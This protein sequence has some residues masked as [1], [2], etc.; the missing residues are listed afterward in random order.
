MKEKGIDI[1]TW[2]GTDVNFA[3]LK[4]LGYTFVIMRIGFGGFSNGF[5]CTE[6]NAFEE[7]YPKAKA[8]GL[9]IGGYWYAGASNVNLAEREAEFCIK[10]LKDK[11]CDLPIFYDVEE[12][13]MLEM[14][15]SQLDDIVNAFCYKLLKNKYYAG[16]YGGFALTGKL[17]ATTRNKYPVW[18]AQWN[19]EC[20][21]SGHYDVW[22]YTDR[23][24]LPS[25]TGGN[26]D[27]DYLYK[28]YTS[29][30][31]DKGYNNFS[32]K[33]PEPV[34]SSKSY[35]QLAFEVIEG[36]YGV[37]DERKQKLGAKYSNV[38]DIVNALLFDS[39]VYLK[40]KALHDRGLL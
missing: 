39:G 1:S 19:S 8:A 31:K 12:K 25:V 17:T 20:Q 6:D 3:E 27:G 40:F 16:I 28:D 26:I 7:N 21:Y 18:F 29:I 4:R 37:G 30:I 36:K 32:V 10:W 22:Q 33:K 5:Y 2:Q 14:Q 35:L 9:K 38:Q 15:N 34:I 13:H 23:L 11:Q 24:K